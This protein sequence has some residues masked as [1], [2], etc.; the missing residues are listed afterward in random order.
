M[1]KELE[2]LER[3]PPVRENLAREDPRFGKQ[4]LVE[5]KVDQV[6]EEVGLAFNLP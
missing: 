4:R 1:N 2:G 3:L 5:S 6:V